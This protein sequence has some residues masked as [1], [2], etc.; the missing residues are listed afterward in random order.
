[1]NYS[2]IKASELIAR[3]KILSNMNVAQKRIPQDG[4]FT[5]KTFD[6]RISSMPCINGENIVI[7]ILNSKLDD[8][9]LS[10]LGFNDNNI[11]KIMSA[12]KKPN[13][14]ILITGP[15]GSGKSTTLLSL[16]NL[17]NDGTKKIITIE[18]PVEYKINGI[19][20]IQVNEQIDLT[21][22]N[23]LRST[24][25]QDPDIIVISEIRDEITAQIAIRASLTG[26]LVLATLHTNDCISTY[27][28]LIDMGIAKYLINDSLLLIVS[29]RLLT[30]NDNKLIEKRLMINE[31]LTLD[32]E[33][34][35][36]LNK[37]TLKNDI[38]NNLKLNGFKTMKED[39]IEKGY[40]I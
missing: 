21:F 33:I 13:G 1:M 10:S 26:H 20:Q 37:Y 16:I 25:R 6:L 24:L 8:I 40:S 17:L 9:S 27:S 12:I 29:Q 39:S 11:S 14:L 15:T 28:R 5:Y 36:I 7:R 32:D 4:N 23:I 35:N 34:K 19:I 38:L 2:D 30:K 3:I 18:D 31:L 22:P